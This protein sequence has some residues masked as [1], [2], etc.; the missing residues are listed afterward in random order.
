[1][2]QAYSGSAKCS[3]YRGWNLGPK[4][5]VGRWKGPGNHTWRAHGHQK[6]ERPPRSQRDRLALEAAVLNFQ[7][8]PKLVRSWR[9]YECLGF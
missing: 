8:M 3:S 7:V 9:S 1:M 2:L 5:V 4:S 6:G